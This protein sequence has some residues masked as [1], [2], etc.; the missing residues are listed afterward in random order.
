MRLAKVRLSVR[1][2]MV[3][4]LL[5]GGGLGWYIREV[6]LQ[7]AAVAAVEKARGHVGYAWEY[8]DDQPAYGGKPRAPAWLIGRL[9]VD[10]FEP[11][12]S[13]GIYQ[14]GTDADLATIGN[15]RRLAQLNVIGA[16]MTDEG[17]A[18]LRGV[19]G[20]RSLS[21]SSVPIT[22]AGLRH[23]ALKRLRWLI[24]QNTRITDASLPLLAG[25]PE[26]EYLDIQGTRITDAGLAHLRDLPSLTELS[27]ENAS[28]TDAGLVHLRGLPKLKKLWLGGSKV[29]PAGVEELK[30]ALGHPL[31]AVGIP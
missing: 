25:L 16:K 4:V 22:D 12:V 6:R 28:V 13:V 9:G 15:L 2:L 23:L 11:V 21:L 24:L 27:L 30:R 26:L 7:I 5:V 19:T 29:T 20:F 1:T 31:E 18:S 8:K 17:L 10:Y 3:L 14:E